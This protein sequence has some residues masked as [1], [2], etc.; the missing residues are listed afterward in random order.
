VSN[1]DEVRWKRRMQN[2]DRALTQ[3]ASACKQEE[4]S[5]LE[6]A[7]LVQVFEFTFELSWKT[8]KDLLFYEG[9]DEKSPRD[10]IRR[11]F[12]VDYLSESECE[13]YL[14]ALNKRNKLSHTYHEKTAIEAERLIKH[15][16]FPLLL[17]IF[18]RLN[19]KLES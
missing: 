8:L 12:A 6:R 18:R 15:K 9:Y 2:F 10:V 11:S 5:E 14:D 13:V 4:Y 19:K 16:Y 17:N 7:G 3:L 1:S